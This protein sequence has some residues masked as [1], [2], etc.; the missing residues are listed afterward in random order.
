MICLGAACSL[1]FRSTAVQSSAG[2]E[3]DLKEEG[4]ES[5][6][7]EFGVIPFVDTVERRTV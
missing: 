4:K 3:K 1:A 2:T 7:A 5:S 6:H